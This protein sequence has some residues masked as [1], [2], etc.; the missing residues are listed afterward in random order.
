M[1]KP[2]GLEVDDLTANEAMRKR[3]R[4]LFDAVDEYEER[5]V[6]RFVA[7]RRWPRPVPE[8][9]CHFLGLILQRSR[10]L[11]WGIL[12]GIKDHNFL[13][14]ILCTRAHY[15]CTG[16]LAYCLNCLQNMYDGKISAEKASGT[17]DTLMIGYRTLPWEVPE[18]FQIDS[19]NVLTGIDTADK[20]TKKILSR[21][22]A[23][24][25]K[26]YDFLCELCH[27][28]MLGIRI[29]ARPTPDFQ[30]YDLDRDP[31]LDEVELETV[32]NYAKLSLTLFLLCYD[33]TWKLL[34]AKEKILPRLIKRVSPTPSD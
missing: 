14:A 16:Y 12:G 4:E 9:A 20:L 7:P 2:D 1:G 31:I 29:G 13:A 27:P 10:L 6:E 18:K 11:L 19:L 22:T 15:E 17:L 34:R 33:T 28:N 30:C 23:V 25:R 21:D 26:F 32:Q 24:F 3:L 8:K 5:F